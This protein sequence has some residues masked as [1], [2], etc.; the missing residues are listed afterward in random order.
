MGMG[1]ESRQQI[2][3]LEQICE[4]LQPNATHYEGLLILLAVFL[5]S[6]RGR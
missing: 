4:A 6:G 5:T 1:T 2:I 3:V